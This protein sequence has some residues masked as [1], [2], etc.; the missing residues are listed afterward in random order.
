MMIMTIHY[1]AHVAFASAGLQPLVGQTAN[2]AE[3]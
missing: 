2:L 1:G 3:Y